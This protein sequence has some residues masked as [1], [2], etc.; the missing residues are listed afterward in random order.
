MLVFK[1]FLPDQWKVFTN[2]GRTRGA[3]V[4]ISDGYIHFSKASQLMETMSKHFSDYEDLVLA[5]CKTEKF[6]T[7][8]KWE[9]SRRG[10]DFPHLYR[11]L[12]MAD[13]EWHT[14]LKK[15]NGHHSLP[16][17]INEII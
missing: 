9:P 5:A 11:E 12:L 10:Q 3:P 8:L 13:I 14:H 1:I 6:S 16:E 7:D 4:D 17:S 2:D 15:K